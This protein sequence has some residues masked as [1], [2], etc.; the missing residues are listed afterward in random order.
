MRPLEDVR[1]AHVR[2]AAECLGFANAPRRESIERFM[3]DLEVP[4]HHPRWKE[5]VPRDRGAGWDFDDVCDYYVRSLFGVDPGELRYANPDRYLDLSRAAVCTAMEAAYAEWRSARSSTG[6]ALV[7]FL[8][9]FWPGAGWGVIDAY[10]LPKAAYHALS[11]TCQPLALLCTDEG[12]NGVALHAINERAQPL[13]AELAV[14]LY[15]GGEVVVAEAHRP[16]VL[17]PRQVER[18][19]VD[20][21]LERVL[22]SSYAYRFGPPQHDLLVAKLSAHGK[23]LAR[24]FH[25]P[26]GRLR[27]LE[28]ELGL[29]GQLV[30]RDDLT[31]AL[32]R[33]RRF[34]QRVSIE[35]D[36]HVPSDD[37]FHLSPGEERWI[38]L[39]PTAPRRGSVRGRITALN[40]LAVGTL[41]FTDSTS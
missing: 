29:S 22:D 30:T 26:L 7:W 37:F 40:T 33:T 39:V 41:T 6:G 10:G 14:T 24:A 13:E 27:P 18:V 12:L 32:V 9:D 38:E 15:R 23:V 34:A 28:L 21:M 36:D 2:F 31:F 11:R 4:P 8:K 5:R 16:L 25:E 3:R 17:A 20:G 1:R 19:L 35:V